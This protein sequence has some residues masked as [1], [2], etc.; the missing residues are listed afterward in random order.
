MMLNPL[1]DLS[2]NIIH[3]GP[4]GYLQRP[5]I[6]QNSAA[7]ME[8]TA[9]FLQ[10]ET[11][12]APQDVLDPE[13]SGKA[14]L[15]QA[16]RIDM[17]T[18][19]IMDSIRG[20]LRHAGEVYR[21]IAADVYSEHRTVTALGIDGGEY[22][23][24][25]FDTVM[26]QQTGRLVQVNDLTRGRFEVVVDTGPGYQ[27]KRQET[28]ANLK[29]ILQGLGA[30]PQAQQYVPVVM[31]MLIENMDGVGLEPLKKYNSRIMLEMG[32]R[33]P[34]DEEEEAM[35]QQMREAAANQPPAA[36]DLLMQA[37]AEKEAATAQ[38]RLARAGNYQ[39]DTKLKESEFI[40]NIAGA[41]LDRARTVDELAQ[42][43]QRRSERLLLRQG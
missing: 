20:A 27:S 41:E 40:R 38:E 43:R 2:G 36:A 31:A 33:E 5:T 17:N 19:P 39:A 32:L 4:L 42:A 28:V 23:A 3:Q 16:A 30:N 1:R 25:L 34:E 24:R 26:D 6:D 15:A 21:W 22:E 18:Q 9:N 29:D 37:T 8:T 35:L 11:G 13:G 10:Q 12:G 7:L 14:I